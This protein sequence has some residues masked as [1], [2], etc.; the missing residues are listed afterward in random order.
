MA[1]G[2]SDQPRADRLTTRVTPEERPDRHGGQGEQDQDAEPACGLGYLAAAAELIRSGWAY[3][4]VIDHQPPKSY[5]KL[6]MLVNESTRMSRWP[7]A[8]NSACR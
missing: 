7:W 5:P 6:K 8:E 1:R 2:G 4:T 3:A